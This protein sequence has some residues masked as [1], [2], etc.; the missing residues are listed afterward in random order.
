MDFFCYEVAH[1]LEDVILWLLTL[2]MSFHD[3]QKN[4]WRIIY[5]QVVPFQPFFEDFY[6]AKAKLLDEHEELK[7]VGYF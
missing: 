3:L 5:K 1:E 4:W 2:K 7:E 6:F